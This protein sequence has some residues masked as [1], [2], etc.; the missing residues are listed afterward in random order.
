MNYGCFRVDLTELKFSDERPAGY[1][2]GYGAVFGNVDEGGDLIE[3]GAFGK[4][5]TE[6]AVK[7]GMPSMYYNHD[8]GGGT[9]GVWEKMSEDSFGLHVQGRLIGL[10]TDP[11]RMMHARLREGAIKGMSIGYRAY[12]G[13]AKM[14]SG[15]VGEPRR[16]LKALHL[17][18]VSLVDNPMNE[19]AR[20][21]FVKGL[22]L[23]AP[24]IDPRLWRTIEAELKSA[25]FNLS[26]AAAVRAVG[27]IKKHL[28]D[29]GVHEADDT[30]RDDGKS[31][32]TAEA[33]ERL[34]DHIRS[35][36]KG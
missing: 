19:L 12:P 14:G 16:Y 31:A 21:N 20:Q 9:I 35:L 29:A 1:F 36:T 22:D 32:E 24:D 8:R 26:N 2:E 25:P 11:G 6:W 5:L 30:L 33:L 4:S 27:V 34:A 3:V 13:G 18:E 17:K 23:Q 28:R 7:G 15:R 10:D